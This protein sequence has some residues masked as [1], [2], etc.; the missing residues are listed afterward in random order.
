MAF[1]NCFFIPFAIIKI[2]LQGVKLI[3]RSQASQKK[4]FLR[5]ND[6]GG[7]P[8]FEKELLHTAGF[9]GTGWLNYIN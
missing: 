6:R 4:R 9:A 3:K 8:F 7:L 2:S 5:E 1:E